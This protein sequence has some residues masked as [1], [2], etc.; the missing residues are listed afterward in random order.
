MRDLRLSCGFAG[1]SE[2]SAPTD[3]GATARCHWSRWAPEWGRP[4]QQGGRELDCRGLVSERCSWI[5]WERPSLF[6]TEC[7]PTTTTLSEK[8]R[9]EIITLS[10]YLLRDLEGM[11]WDCG[12]RLCS[13]IFFALVDSNWRYFWLT[14]GENF[15]PVDMV[16]FL[17]TSS[18]ASLPCFPTVFKRKG[19]WLSCEN[20]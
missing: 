4:S 17:S 9:D 1:Q 15:L 18:S 10:P 20:A 11:W 3:G 13:S 2:M 7:G 5:G 12:Q 8:N 6:S 19:K 14:F 16:V